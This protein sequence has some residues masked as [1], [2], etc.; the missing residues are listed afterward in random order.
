MD[1]IVHYD[2]HIGDT[3]VLNSMSVTMTVEEVN[4]EHISVV[5]Y[6]EMDG[7]VYARVFNAAML[8]KVESPT[9][10]PDS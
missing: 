6:N 4:G 9:D 1:E 7:L 2:F 10:A 3:V 8:K 5:W